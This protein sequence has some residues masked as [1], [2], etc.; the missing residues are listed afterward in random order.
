[1][2]WA[3]MH[4][5][6]PLNSSWS[7]IDHR[8]SLEIDQHR[9]CQFQPYIKQGTNWLCQVGIHQHLIKNH[10]KAIRHIRK[11]VTIDVALTIASTMV[12]ARLDNCNAILHRT[13]KSNIQ[14]QQRA[15]N[16]IA[17]IV[18][19]TRWLEHITPVLARLHW[20]KIAD[21]IECKVALLTFKALKQA[22]LSGQLQLCASVWQL[23]SSDRN[24]RLYLNSHR[25]TFAS[26]AFRNAAPIIWNSMSHQLTDDLSC[27]A[28]FHHNLKTHLFSKSFRHWLLWPVRNYDSS[29]Y[30]WLTYVASPT[31]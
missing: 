1:M 29:I 31:A 16:S 25:T 28:S 11:R 7:R 14:K 10:A 6:P 15:Q 19:G 5:L 27:P 3:I 23:R 21:R 12:S 13:S 4:H 8:M 22:S 18:T 9:I 24:N 2:E 26:R 20:L 17:C 30:F